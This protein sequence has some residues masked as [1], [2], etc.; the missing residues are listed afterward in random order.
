MFIVKRYIKYSVRRKEREK[1]NVFNLVERI[2]DNL[3]RYQQESPN[4]RPAFIPVNRLRDE[5]IPPMERKSKFN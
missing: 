1:L 3:M 2:V 5:M 4:G